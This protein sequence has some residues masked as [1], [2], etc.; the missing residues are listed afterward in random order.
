MSGWCHIFIEAFCMYD[1]FSKKVHKF[2]NWDD[3]KR[4]IEG[5]N[6]RVK[7]ETRKNE[8]Y[9]SPNKRPW[10]CKK[11]NKNRLPQFRYLCDEDYNKQCPFFCYTDADKKDYITFNKAWNKRNK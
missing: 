5:R 9:V 7:W 11:F 4:K 2:A 3:V 8:A 1:H 10:W 6:I